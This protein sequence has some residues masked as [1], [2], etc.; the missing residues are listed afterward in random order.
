MG[1]HRLGVDTGA[2]LELAVSFLSVVVRRL[3][4]VEM[5]A[6]A[7]HAAGALMQSAGALMQL[8]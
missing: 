2:E 5:R 3:P 8:A 6:L 7:A 4:L 1:F